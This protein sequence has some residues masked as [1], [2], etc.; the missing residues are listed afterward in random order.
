MPGII[1]MI[2]AGVVIGP[3]GLNLLERNSSFI[4]FGTVGLLYIMFTAGLEIDMEDFKK[5]RKT[6]IMFGLTSFFLPQILGMAA[7]FYILGF[8]VPASILLGALLGSHTLLAYPA[9]SKLGIAKSRSVTITV[10]GT[11]IADLFSLL[12]LAIIASAA[13]G[14]LGAGFWLRLVISLVIYSVVVIWGLPKVSRWFFRNVESESVAQYIFVLAV[15]FVTG[16]MAELAG[17]EAII[18][19]FLAGLVL[20]QL[21]PHRSPLMNRIEFVGNAVFIPF[22]LISVGMLVDVR[23]LFQGAEA[24]IVA[25]T[26]LLTATISKWL[27]AWLTEQFF[28]FT[29]VERNVIFGLSNARAAATLTAVLV[30]FEL[31]V[32]DESVLNGAVIMILFTCIIS[33]IVTEQA[34]RKLAIAESTKKVDLSSEPSRILVPISNPATLEH[35]VDFAILLKE[36]SSRNPIYPLVVVKDGADAETQLVKGNK[37]L[38]RAIHHAAAVDEQVQLVPRIDMNVSSGIL[39][40]IRELLITKVVIGWNGTFTT[41]QRVFGSILDNLLE[42]SYQSI[43][44]CKILHPLNTMNRMIVAA[45]AN[46]GLEKGFST[47]LLDLHRMAKQIGVSLVIYSD[48][49]TESQIQAVLVKTPVNVEKI[50]R[51]VD[52]WTQDL[53]LMQEVTPDDLLVVVSARAATLSYDSHLDRVPRQL[54]R[55]FGNISFVI[56]Y[57]EQ[58]PVAG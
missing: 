26:M 25:G 28:D 12:V 53:G 49:E 4:L 45:P 17:L 31:K 38:E 48:R 43:F 9:A 50:F 23:V 41:R 3:N 36:P 33:S 27:A 39:R 47:W 11:I 40:A 54:A 44:V 5:N 14:E 8:G 16:F 52:N 35:L 10:G 15:V 57:P 21:I 22:F 51:N 46:A 29:P 13:R 19:A 34:G 37:M 20:N 24:W 1:G 6:S 58:H 7:G 32:L 42:G 55:S 56:L 18:G 30:G 2:L